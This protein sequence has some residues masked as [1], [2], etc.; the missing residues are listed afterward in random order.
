MNASIAKMTPVIG[1]EVHGVDLARLDGDTGAWIVKALAEHKVLMFRDQRITPEQHKAVARL[2][3]TGRIH[4][5]HLVRG[6]TADDEITPVNHN[7]E[8]TFNI[9]DG[10]HS[11]ASCD[12]DPIAASVFHLKQMPPGG[13]GD[14]LFADMHEC[15][16]RLSAPLQD[17]LTG[18]TALHDGGKGYGED[19]GITA[20]STG[21]AY[22]STN[23][24]IV[25]DHPV[26]GK[27]LLFVNTGFTTRI[28]GL[29]AHESRA[30]LDMLFRHIDLTVS[31]HLRIRWQEG[32]VAIWDN[33][34]TQ[35][36][37]IW[38]YFPE[39]RLADRVSVIG[40]RIDGA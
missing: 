26:T 21:R 5:H 23:H 4:V 22:N 3:G 34:A 15:W 33:V 28:N 11:D 10:W 31:A 7:A 29:A 17:M 24:P 39:T 2:F 35:H 8:S 32:S 1:A 16:R 20:E 36:Q 6:R 9:G 18:M 37:A 14:T 38:D 27:K 19:Y 13:G 30:L 12:P 25:I 40:P